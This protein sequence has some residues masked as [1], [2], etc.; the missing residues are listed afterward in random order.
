MTPHVW[1]TQP[2]LHRNIHLVVLPKVTSMSHERQ[3][4]KPGCHSYKVSLCLCDWGKAWNLHFQKETDVWVR[5]REELVA[6]P[7]STSFSSFSSWSRRAS[8][9]RWP[10]T[11]LATVVLSLTAAQAA[12]QCGTSVTQVVKSV[13]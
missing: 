11:E 2:L 3:T 6:P 1:H 12:L 13:T 9:C 8:L 5:S 10:G 7:S 4:L